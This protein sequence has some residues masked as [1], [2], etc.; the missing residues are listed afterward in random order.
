[1]LKFFRS[2]QN[3]SEFERLKKEMNEI[4]LKKIELVSKVM[5]REFTRLTLCF[6]YG[7]G[8]PFVPAFIFSMGP[9]KRY[10]FKY[11]YLKNIE[12]QK[13]TILVTLIFI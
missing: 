6:S 1:M 5:H 13:D 9:L 12:K 3:R 4:G 11:F 10:D 7:G 2:K 8:L